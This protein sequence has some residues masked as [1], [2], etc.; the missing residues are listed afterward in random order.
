MKLAGRTIVITG[1]GGGIGGAVAGLIAEQGAA[2]VLV[3]QN[4]EAAN[5]VLSGLL[6]GDHEVALADVSD[7]AELVAL[8]QRLAA[9]GRDLAGV[10]NAAGIVTGGEPWPDS[11]L[12]K[13]A[14]VL[15]VNAL[16][17]AVIST[18][19][20][21]YPYRKSDRVVVNV[22]SVAAVRPHP[23]DPTYAASKAAVVAFTR[24]AAAA[25]TGTRFNAVLP[26]VVR[27]AML[28][29]TGSQGVAPWIA[30]RLDGPLLSPE[31]VAAVI[32]DQVIGDV[33][34]QVLT[35]ELDKTDPSRMVT[36]A[37]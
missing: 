36:M 26:G 15:G 33:D 13:I 29:T 28:H 7:P 34:G 5:A 25:S 20:A 12:D 24:S 16:G 22:S 21:Q 27:T 8:F 37:L 18:L 1:G 2:V 17:T 31:Q 32:T 35:V 4:P 14:K 10:V 30:P 3:D 19:A 6:A 23:P 9:A 11:D